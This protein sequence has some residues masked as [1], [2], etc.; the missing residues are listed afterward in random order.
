MNR[1]R[2][3]LCAALVL[4][5]PML[6]RAQ[7]DQDAHG[8]TLMGAVTHSAANHVMLTTT[9]GREVHVAITPDTNI[10]RGSDRMRGAD[11]PTGARVVV[12]LM[13]QDEPYVAEDIDVGRID[14]NDE[15]RPCLASLDSQSSLSLA[16]WAPAA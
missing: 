1:R 13:S 14:R 5:V 2:A 6:G 8:R 9:G 16:R 12:T 11:I 7:H 10:V 3:A 15:V 4:A